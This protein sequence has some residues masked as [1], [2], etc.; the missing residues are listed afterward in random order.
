MRDGFAVC[1]WRRTTL[2][3]LSNEKVADKHEF[4]VYKMKSLLHHGCMV[5]RKLLEDSSE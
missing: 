2:R 3:F 5:L 1:L 4:S